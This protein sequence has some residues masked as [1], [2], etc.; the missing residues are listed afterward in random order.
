[1]SQL[2]SGK[3]IMQT[4]PRNFLLNALSERYIRLKHR[5]KE[6]SANEVLNQLRQLVGEEDFSVYR[7]KL[8]T[9]SLL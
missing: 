3:D 9:A 7:E 2:F 5:R 4:E 8:S 6:E 1:M